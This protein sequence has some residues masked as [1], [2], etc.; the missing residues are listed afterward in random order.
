[1]LSRPLDLGCAEEAPELLVPLEARKKPVHR[2][3]LGIFCGAST[4]WK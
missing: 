2:R 3:V 1:M 4:I